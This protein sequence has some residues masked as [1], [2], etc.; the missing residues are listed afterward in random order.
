MQKHS[1]QPN[2]NSEKSNVQVNEQTTTEA[3]EVTSLYLSSRM[4][5]GGLSD[6][7][8]LLNRT[9]SSETPFDEE[10]RKDQ[11]LTRNQLVLIYELGE[12]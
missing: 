7:V 1:V 2:S 5:A 4:F 9:L 10:Q 8:D 11:Q 12:N 3:P 6:I